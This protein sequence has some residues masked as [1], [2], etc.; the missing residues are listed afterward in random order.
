MRHI[1][2]ILICCSILADL[3][4]ANGDLSDFKLKLKL[5]VPQT[6]LEDAL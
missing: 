4:A 3:A 6:A 1:Q 2:P 5:K